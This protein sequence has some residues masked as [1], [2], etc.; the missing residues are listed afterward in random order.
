MV[1]QIVSE[2]NL[3]LQLLTISIIGVIWGWSY[4]LVVGYLR[5]K[6]DITYYWCHLVG[7]LVL[8]VLFG[9]ILYKSHKQKTG[10]EIEHVH[11]ANRYLFY[12]IFAKLFVQIGL[13]A[14]MVRAKVQWELMRYTVSIVIALSIA[15]ICSLRFKF[16]RLA[17][18][19]LRYSVKQ[20]QT[21]V[22]GL[23]ARVVKLGG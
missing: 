3:W 23:E 11:D 14:I 13:L 15:L 12:A 9:F 2:Y 10:I 6:A 20:L 8:V 17:R 22:A 16:T 7:L 1:S 5:E 4:L 21:Q 19:N 18:Q